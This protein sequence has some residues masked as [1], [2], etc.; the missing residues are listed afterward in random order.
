MKIEIVLKIEHDKTWPEICGGN[1]K[2][3]INHHIEKLKS[4]LN[5][6][7]AASI[8]QKWYV[9]QESNCSKCVFNVNNENDWI[10]HLKADKAV[11]EGC[12]LQNSQANIS[13]I[14]DYI[15]YKICPYYHPCKRFME[16]TTWDDDKKLKLEL[17]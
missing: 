6:H 14:A 9:S 12:A 16:N 15:Q 3:V 10:E 5:K 7:C 2:A 4:D 17:L 1:I 13:M 11:L 8:E